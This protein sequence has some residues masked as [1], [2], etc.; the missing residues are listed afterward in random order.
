[1]CL[2]HEKVPFIQYVLTSLKYHRFQY[3]DFGVF[4]FN[5]K[6]TLAK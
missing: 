1:M 2:Y 3:I 5:Y 4:R 6:A